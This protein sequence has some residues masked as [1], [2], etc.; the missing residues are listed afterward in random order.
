MLH[1]ERLL[2]SVY[3]KEYNFPTVLQACIRFYQL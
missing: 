2:K 1:E 3:T